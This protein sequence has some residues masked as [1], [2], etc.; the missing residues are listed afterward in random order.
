[1]LTWMQGC[2]QTTL[3]WMNGFTCLFPYVFLIVLTDVDVRMHL[4]HDVNDLDRFPVFLSMG[5]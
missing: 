3:F 1:M 2:T 4:N 5:L